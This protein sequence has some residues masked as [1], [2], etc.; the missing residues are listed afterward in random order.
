MGEVP[1]TTRIARHAGC[2]KGNASRALAE[3]VS[4]GLARRGERVGR[5]I[6]YLPIEVKQQ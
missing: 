4:Q 6:P 1:T 2:D 5:E 3:L